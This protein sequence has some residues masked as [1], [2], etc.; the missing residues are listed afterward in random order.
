MYTNK[1]KIFGCL[2]WA[3]VYSTYATVKR[4]LYYLY[5]GNKAL[6]NHYNVN[7]MVFGKEENLC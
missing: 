1:K 3:S 7:K 6:K 5:I 2:H 4:L